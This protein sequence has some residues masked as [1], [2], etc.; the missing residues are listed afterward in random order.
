MPGD[1]GQC[2]V[3]LGKTLDISDQTR[4]SMLRI[5]N[6]EHLIVSSQHF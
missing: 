4:H 6:D 1:I 3:D 5:A 2:F